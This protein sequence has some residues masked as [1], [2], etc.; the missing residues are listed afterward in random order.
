MLAGYRA[1][2]TAYLVQVHMKE[3]SSAC[4]A[5]RAPIA[6]LLHRQDVVSV[7][8]DVQVTRLVQLH[9]LTANQAATLHLRGS[10]NACH[11]QITNTVPF[12]ARLPVLDAANTK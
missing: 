8:Q 1:A 2:L 6:I 9:A 12:D 4:N 11:A 5:S 7:R 3:L 10:D